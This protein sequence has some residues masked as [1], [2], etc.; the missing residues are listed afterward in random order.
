[1]DRSFFGRE[2]G[3]ALLLG[4][5]PFGTGFR[6]ES[7]TRVTKHYIYLQKVRSY[8]VHSELDIIYIVNMV[9]AIALGRSTLLT[10]AIY[11][12]LVHSHLG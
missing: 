3:S 10:L 8:S 1:L 7:V 12:A 9:K 6:G 5:V 2:R 4:N 11:L